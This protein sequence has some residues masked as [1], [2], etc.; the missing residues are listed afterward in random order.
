MCVILWQ[1]CACDCPLL[2]LLDSS[3]WGAGQVMCFFLSSRR[4]GGCGLGRENTKTY[5]PTTSLLLQLILLD[6]FVF[7]FSQVLTWN[8]YFTL[9]LSL[10]F[11]ITL[12]CRPLPWLWILSERFLTSTKFSLFYMWDS[13]VFLLVSLFLQHYMIILVTVLLLFYFCK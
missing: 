11:A 6:L 5:L 12:V 9:F 3:T 10:R 13:N 2:P 7:Y 8:A 4:G 1:L